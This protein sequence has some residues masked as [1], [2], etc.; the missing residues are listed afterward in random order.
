M[1]CLQM[2]CTSYLQYHMLQVVSTDTA[3]PADV[4]AAAKLREDG[5]TDEIIFVTYATVRCVD[6]FLGDT[7]A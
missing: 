2:L 4:I 5:S 7:K 1:S 3:P 6:D